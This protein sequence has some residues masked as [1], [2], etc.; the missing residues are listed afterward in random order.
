MSYESDVFL[1]I[2]YV[3]KMVFYFNIY[4]FIYIR[5]YIEYIFLYAIINNWFMIY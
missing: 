1:Y 3:F 4:W 5:K 2:K